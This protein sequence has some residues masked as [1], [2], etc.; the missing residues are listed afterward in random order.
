[1]AHFL[2]RPHILNGPE[3]V[4]TPDIMI[5]QVYQTLN[6]QYGIDLLDVG[7][8]QV[9]CTIEIHYKSQSITITPAY[10]LVAAGGGTLLSV[11]AEVVF[12]EQKIGAG[13]MLLPRFAWRLKYLTEHWDALTLQVC[14]D[15]ENVREN[16]SDIPLTKYASPEAVM[17]VLPMPERELPRGVMTFVTATGV[18]YTENECTQLSLTITDSVSGMRLAHRVTLIPP[19]QE[20]SEK[21]PAPRYSVGPTSGDIKHYI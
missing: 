19:N 2:Y 4:T 21:R 20:A 14:S 11:A 16:D 3:G 9:T 5:D 17:D 1:M 13:F 7:V 12:A 8:N 18:T 15:T 6:T 10:V